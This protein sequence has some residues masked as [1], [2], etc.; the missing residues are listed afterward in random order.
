MGRGVIYIVEEPR[1]TLEEVSNSL[2]R[3]AVDSDSTD[4]P[5]PVRLTAL[6]SVLTVRDQL[7]VPLTLAQQ[8]LEPPRPQPPVHGCRYCYWRQGG[9]GVSQQSGQQCA[10]HRHWG[11]VCCSATDTPHGVKCEGCVQGDLS[12]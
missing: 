1:G 8:L 4:P 7:T 6:F 9:V 2:V 11:A 5:V 3:N 10:V 12:S